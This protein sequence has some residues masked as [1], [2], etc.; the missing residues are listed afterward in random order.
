MPEIRASSLFM[1]LRQSAGSIILR[2]IQRESRG[3]R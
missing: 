1:Q 2:K 3:L